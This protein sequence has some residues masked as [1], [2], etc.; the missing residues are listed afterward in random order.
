VYV[1]ERTGVRRCICGKWLSDEALRVERDNAGK[2][3]Y[4][5]DGEMMVA[6]AEKNDA[7][8]DADKEVAAA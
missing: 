2:H 1:V 7:H 6:I 3:A 5:R 8:F 4:N